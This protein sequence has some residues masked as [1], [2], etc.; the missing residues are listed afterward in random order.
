MQKQEKKKERTIGRVDPLADGLSF[1]KSFFFVSFRRVEVSA[2][3]VRFVPCG[4]DHEE[5]VSPI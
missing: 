4:V 1:A 2:R 5:R 3:S